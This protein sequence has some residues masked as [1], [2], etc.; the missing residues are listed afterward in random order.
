VL[1]LVPVVFICSCTALWVRPSPYVLHCTEKHRTL[2][3]STCSLDFRFLGH[4]RLQPWG[5]T[6]E[7][8][9]E[10]PGPLP[11]PHELPLCAGSSPHTTRP[12]EARHLVHVPTPPEVSGPSGGVIAGVRFTRDYHPRHLPPLVFLKPSTVY[13]SRR[14]ACSVSH[15]HHLWDSKNTNSSLR[16]LAVPTGPSEDSPIL[17][18]E[19]RSGLSFRKMT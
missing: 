16:F 8:G 6:S 5:C 1:G 14:L 9:Y 17:D 19:A 18:H 2:R 12:A 10:F 3:F 11:W 13:S 15:R 4:L 7:T